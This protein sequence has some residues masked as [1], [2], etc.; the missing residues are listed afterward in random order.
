MLKFINDDKIPEDNLLWY[1]IVIA[2]IISTVDIST[3]ILE[4]SAPILAENMVKKLMLWCLVYIKTK[5]IYYS[6][7][8]SILIIILFPKIFFGK[9]TSPAYEKYMKSK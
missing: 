8:I 9:K 3:E 1:L 2:S 6:C 4:H 7:L 5:S